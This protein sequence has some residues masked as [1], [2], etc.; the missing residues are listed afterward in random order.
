MTSNHP[1]SSSLAE[2]VAV[3]TTSTKRRLALDRDAR[4]D[5]EFCSQSCDEESVSIGDFGVSRPLTHSME[6]VTTMVGTPC[7][8]SPEASAR[9]F[10]RAL[11]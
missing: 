11:R 5:L 8:L 1:T 9:R 10:C 7:Y 4:S 6:L 3:P 2:V